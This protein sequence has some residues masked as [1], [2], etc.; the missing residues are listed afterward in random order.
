MKSGLPRGEIIL[1]RL[2]HNKL[3]G[4]I[5]QDL[6]GFEADVARGEAFRVILR[7][8]KIEMGIFEDQALKLD[9]AAILQFFQVCVRAF[10]TNRRP[11]VASSNKDCSPAK[12]PGSPACW[13]FF[14]AAA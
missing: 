14:T 11:A 1:P 12:A 3:S 13:A 8:L 4:A 7:Q 5:G 6:A 10:C 2:K 9:R